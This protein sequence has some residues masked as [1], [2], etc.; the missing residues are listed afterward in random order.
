MSEKTTG[1]KQRAKKVKVI[2]YL[3][4]HLVERLREKAESERRAMSVI[5]ELVLEKNL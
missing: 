4:L 3:P 5:V 1:K 2:Y